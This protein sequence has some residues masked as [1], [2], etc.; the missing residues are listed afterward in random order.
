MPDVGWIEHR[1]G[2][3]ALVGWLVPEG[4]A[5]HVIDLLG[6]THTSVPLDWFDAEETLDAL[7]IGYLADQYSLRLADGTER[8]VR[9]GDVSTAGILAVA[10]DFGDALAIGSKPE[11]FSLPF[12]APD[13]LT[14]IG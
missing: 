10:D 9:I 11:L 13:E 2:D 7:G 12:P 4:E 3:G 6:R 1:R 8:R 14:W 5:F